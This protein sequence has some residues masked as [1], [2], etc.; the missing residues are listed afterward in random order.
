MRFIAYV[1]HR[2]LEPIQIL[3]ALVFYGIFFALIYRNKAL[4]IPHFPKYISVGI[5]GLKALSVIG[6][7]FIYTNVYQD[8]S[9]VDIYKYYEDGMAIA[10]YKNDTWA[11]YFRILFGLENDADI[12]YLKNYTSHWFKAF[13]EFSY[14]E[15]RT[16]IRFHALLAPFTFHSYFA[17]SAITTFLSYAGTL[18]LFKTW[19]PHLVKLEK[20]WLFACFLLPSVLFWNAGV[21]KE[22]F[23]SF[24]LGLLVNALFYPRKKL[25]I[26]PALLFL[27]L[28]KEYI[29][30]AVLPALT[31]SLIKSKSSIP[32]WK[33]YA[34]SMLA[35]ALLVVGISEFT[36]F[37]FWNIIQKKQEAFINVSTI[38]NAKSQIIIPILEPNAYSILKASPNAIVNTL[39]RPFFT[40][41]KSPLYLLSLIENLFIWTI[42]FWAI[43]KIKWK[44]IKNQS[45]IFFALSFIITLALIIGLTVDNT[46]SI[47]R[48]RMPILPFLMAIFVYILSQKK[49]NYDLD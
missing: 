41:I 22:P 47:V 49:T 2:M 28:S 24:G 37:N 38:N 48:Y 4:Q 1:C 46:G 19:Y 7:F 34:L 10:N 25:L 39:F 3:S 9:D 18:L 13:E 21:I 33:V 17:H 35:F 8:H 45:F 27:F 5:F 15:N 20:L 11:G 6:Y 43:F 12:L 36:S 32:A 29:F 31:A 16:I 30:L 23:V 42:G 40:E 14:N 44:K 26:F